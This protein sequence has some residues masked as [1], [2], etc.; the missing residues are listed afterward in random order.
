ME[1]RDIG[2]GPVGAEVRDYMFIQIPQ[3]P[4]CPSKNNIFPA[5]DLQYFPLTHPIFYS[6]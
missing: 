1:N 4:P 2:C 6:F 5:I 3:F